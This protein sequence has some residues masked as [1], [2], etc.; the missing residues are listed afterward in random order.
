[1]V[2]LIFDFATEEWTV[3]AVLN[4]EWYNFASGL[5]IF[6]SYLVVAWQGVFYYNPKEESWQQLYE[7]SIME[8]LVVA[9]H[10]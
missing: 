2:T 7:G 3:G 1:M 8:G 10:Y 6:D 9:K 4:T 5:S